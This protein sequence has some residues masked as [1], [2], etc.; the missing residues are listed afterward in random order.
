MMS[1]HESRAVAA[2]PFRAA[3]L[4]NFAS[5]QWEVLWGQVS[6]FIFRVPNFGFRVPDFGNQV[7]NFGFRVP[8]F[9]YH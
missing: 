3:H 5:F 2:E 7:S 9:W 6:G 4:S 8:D 1:P